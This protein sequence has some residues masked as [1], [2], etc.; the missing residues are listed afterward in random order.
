MYVLVGILLLIVIVFGAASGMQSYASAKQAQAAIEVAQ[1]AQV[2]AWGNLIVLLTLALLIVCVIGM[3]AWLLLS[4]RQRADAGYRPRPR[5]IQRPDIIPPG[6]PP[7]LETLI[8]L[9]VLKT[10]RALHP[11]PSEPR[12]NAMIA[13]EEE[14][15]DD[16]P[17]L[18]GS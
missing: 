13:A 14:P 16:L 9:E 18:R 2:N 17:W 5:M 11:P 3:I 4:R 15:A 1:V 8:Q 10:L 6:P 7:T 12:G